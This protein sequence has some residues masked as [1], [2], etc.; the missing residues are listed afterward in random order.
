MSRSRII[1]HP[2]TLG[3][4]GVFDLATRCTIRMVGRSRQP[5]AESELKP[6]ERF[7]FTEYLCRF[8]GNCPMKKR[9]ESHRRFT[10]AALRGDEGHLIDNEFP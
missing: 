5:C 6:A 3:Q 8:E 2:L 4:T 9:P 10:R 7:F 1:E